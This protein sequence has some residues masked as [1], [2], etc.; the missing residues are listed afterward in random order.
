MLLPQDS[1]ETVGMILGSREIQGVLALNL[2]TM[3][4]YNVAGRAGRGGRADLPLQC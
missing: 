2:A 4:A 1:I 3:G